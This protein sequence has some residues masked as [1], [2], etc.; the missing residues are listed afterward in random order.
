[1]LDWM[2]APD[3]PAS[4]ENEWVAEWH[5]ADPLFPRLRFLGP[6]SRDPH[7]CGGIWFARVNLP[8]DRRLIA[9]RARLASLP[10]RDDVQER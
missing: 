8:I 5:E 10:S 9:K 1:M 6:Y 7:H 2:H 4:W 3:V